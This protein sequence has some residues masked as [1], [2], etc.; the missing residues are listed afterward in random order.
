M[1]ARIKVVIGQQ[2]SK[3]LIGI[4]IQ[5]QM[6][7]AAIVWMNVTKIRPAKGSNVVVVI[8]VGG[9]MENVMKLMSTLFQATE[10]IKCVSRNLTFEVKNT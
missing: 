9:K 7:T 4:I 8:A 2:E 10:K 3:V 6:E 1:D 5:G